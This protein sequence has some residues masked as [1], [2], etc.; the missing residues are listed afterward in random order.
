LASACSFTTSALAQPK[1][2][3]IW[4]SEADDAPPGGL[5]V[6]L[7]ASAGH[8][9]N[10]AI[11]PTAMAPYRALIGW[12]LQ[13][14][15]GQ[16]GFIPPGGVQ[17]PCD[18]DPQ[19]CVTPPASNF[20]LAKVSAGWD[21]CLALAMDR[22]YNSENWHTFGLLGWGR[23]DLRQA[24]VP[25]LEHAPWNIDGTTQVRT[26]SAGEYI[27]I[28]LFENGQIAAW[29]HDHYG[30]DPRPNGRGT[31]DLYREYQPPADWRFKEAYCG[32]HYVIALRSAPGDPDHD[33]TIVTWGTWDHNDPPHIFG[34]GF[35][36]AQLPT[37][38]ETNPMGRNL[39][40]QN[41]YPPYD[42]I[43]AG[44]VTCGGLRTGGTPQSPLPGILDLWAFDSAGEPARANQ[45][46]GVRFGQVV[47]GYSQFIFGV[48]TDLMLRGWSNSLEGPLPPSGPTSG[49]PPT[50]IVEGN[51]QLVPGNCN[52]LQQ[53]GLCYNPNCDGST[54]APVLNVNDFSC[55]QAAFAAAQQL[56]AD[57]QITSYANC[58][59]S[60]LS[61]VLTVNDLLCFSA[62]FA[63]GECPRSNWP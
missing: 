8:R 14:Q 52:S 9:F 11:I 33:G 19:L 59:G 23:N 12:G 7:D 44:H 3:Y 34:P 31:N 25:D 15:W 36:G 56:P 2:F 5:S 18:V 35:R 39:P 47:G 26:I 16:Q 22:S 4:S 37:H 13:N 21:H 28:V 55:F 54:I 1:A 50:S 30:V 45:P 51:F 57:Q 43:M 61:P 6:V 58:D 41:Y 63:S 29:G 48:D 20:P 32:G 27:N 60:T 40:Q 53:M 38:T 42:R 46:S 10:V 17:F 49:S 24:R 62:A